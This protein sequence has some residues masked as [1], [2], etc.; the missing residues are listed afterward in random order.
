MVKMFGW[1]FLTGRIAFGKAMLGNEA[2]DDIRLWLG[3]ISI[4]P[5]GALSGANQQVV[6]AV[7]VLVCW[8]LIVSQARLLK[9]R[10]VVSPPV[11]SLFGRILAMSNNPL[12]DS[13]VWRFWVGK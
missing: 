11:G 9:D 4:E 10:R 5:L 3:E 2:V 7:E 13:V 6:E 12:A 8:N 1:L